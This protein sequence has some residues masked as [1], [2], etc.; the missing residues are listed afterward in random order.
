MLLAPT[1]IYYLNVHEKTVL[2]AFPHKPKI[3]YYWKSCK[4]HKSCKIFSLIRLGKRIQTNF[5]WSW[6]PQFVSSGVSTTIPTLQLGFTFF[7]VSAMQRICGV[8]LHQPWLQKFCVL[9]HVIIQNSWLRV[10][11]TCLG[12]ALGY[13]C[14]AMLKIKVIC[15]CWIYIVTTMKKMLAPGCKKSCNSFFKKSSVSP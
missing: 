14:S 5:W 10:E 4:K 9:C 3:T 6:L 12:A 1:K 8:F 7:T 15:T 11:L 13:H 2:M